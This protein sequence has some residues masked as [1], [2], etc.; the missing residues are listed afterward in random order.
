MSDLNDLIHTN[1]VNAFQQGVKSERARIYKILKPLSECDEDLCG[2]DGRFCYPDDC[3]APVY[4]DVIQKILDMRLQEITRDDAEKVQKVISV[5]LNADQPARAH[6]SFING[7]VATYE[8]VAEL[9]ETHRK[10]AQF[11]YSL[12]E[13]KEAEVV[14]DAF[15]LFRDTFQDVYFERI[16]KAKG[17]GEQ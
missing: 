16:D 1:A 15:A 10:A 3:F 6:E 5:D 9:L 12:T 17:E 13:S 7:M 11:W 4:R 8:V 14:S 2:E